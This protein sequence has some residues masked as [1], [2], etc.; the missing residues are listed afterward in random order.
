MKI[1]LKAVRIT[2]V[3][4][5]HNNTSKDL[6]IENG[7]IKTIATSIDA[8]DA[9]VVSI[10]QLHVSQGW[11]DFKCGFNDPGS[12]EG[13][14]ILAGLD[15]AALGGFT[16]VGVLPTDHPATETRSAIEYKLSIT[17]HHAVQLHPIGSVSKGRKGQSLAEMADMHEAGTSWYSDNLPLST[18]LSVQALLYARDL[19]SRI[20]FTS[21]STDFSKAF[22]VN[23]G[24]ASTLTGLPGHPAFDEKI[25]VLKLVEM[26][27]Y[28]GVPV[29]ISGISSHESLPIIASAK[30]EGIDLSCDVHL[31]NLCF[32]EERTLD[33]DTCFKVSPVI[34]SEEDRTSLVAALKNGIIDAVVSDH[35]AVVIDAKRVPFDEADFGA[36]QLQTAY[37]ALK[38][39]SGLTSDQVVEWLS[40]HNRK[41]FHLP[42]RPI[43]VDVPA[44]LTLYLTDEKVTT[45]ALP[46]HL[47][48]FFNDQLT[49]KAVGIIRGNQFML[50]Q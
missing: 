17:Q 44:D 35:Q 45:D 21:Q 18:R 30:N 2:D 12:D 50:N 41:A 23:E 3:K 24:A 49:G 27:K 8:A 4:S 26:A 37:S 15:H 31:M 38:K 11:V 48:P 47:S 33:F 19:N 29:H 34:R 46:Q 20:I 32:S 36:L 1:L 16:H 7:V 22:Q 39:Y 40:V 14:G 6:L 28:T 10:P 5:P 13:G 25:Q 43:D 9:T 42:M